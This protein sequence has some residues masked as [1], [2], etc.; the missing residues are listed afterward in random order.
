MDAA[1]ALL[2]QKAE[3]GDLS[4]RDIGWTRIDMVEHPDYLTPN[5]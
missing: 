5:K 3:D 4:A 1:K 2:E